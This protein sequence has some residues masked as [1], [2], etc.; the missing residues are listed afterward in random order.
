MREPRLSVLVVARDE[1]HNL[2]DCLA[3]ARW[4]D[5]R[6]VVVDSTSRD[7]TLEIA[8][9][10]ADVV[11]GPRLRRFRQPAQRRLELASGDW[12]LSVDA[13]ERVTPELADEIR[14]VINDPATPFHGYRVPIRSEVL[15]RRSASPAPSTTFR[16]DSSAAIPGDGSAWSTRRL[17]FAAPLASLENPLSHRHD[18]DDAG[19]PRQD[20]R[21]HDAGGRGLA[22]SRRA[23]RHDRPDAT[24]RSGPSSGSTFSSKG[25]A[26]ASRDSCSAVLGRVD[27][28]AGLETPRADPAIC[29]PPPAKTA[30]AEDS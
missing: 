22:R 29:P 8:R 4:A 24:P 10:D 2:A 17:T 7:A 9:R 20:Q 5:E 12:L 26:T 13:D 30:L 23:Y 11:A 18:P 21:L 1:A 25:S 6:V 19:L 15:G 28:R 3:T 14:R 16:S 27:G